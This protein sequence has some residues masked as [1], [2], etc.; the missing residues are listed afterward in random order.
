MDHF[1]AAIFDLD[2]VLTRT[3]DLHA[4]AWKEMFDAYLHGRDE[5]QAEFDIASDYR[6]YVDGKPR[7]D[8]IRSFLSSRGIELPVGEPEDPPTRD[9]VYGLGHRKNEL[10]RELLENEGVTVYDDAVA[11]LRAWRDDGLKTAVV[12]SSRNGR[13]VL[14]AAGLLDLFDARVDG[15]DS[16]DLGLDGKPAPDIFLE[17]AKQLSV[18][19]EEAIVLEDSVAGVE[20]GR[21]GGFGL[22]VGVE[23]SGEGRLDRH[24]ADVVVTDV[25]ELE[26]RSTIDGRAQD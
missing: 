12:T 14:E 9:T 5:T 16:A 8:G 13:A 3:A 19:P 7:L 2:G 22:V 4:R 23:R 20:A 10:F 1:K 17:A 6:T 15:I 24:G 11:Q 18:E 26:N 21:A 25:R